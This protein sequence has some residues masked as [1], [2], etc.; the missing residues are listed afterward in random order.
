MPWCYITY[1]LLWC[2]IH[3]DIQWR[4]VIHRDILWYV[5]HLQMIYW[6]PPP[7]GKILY[8]IFFWK[9]NSYYFSLWKFTS[10]TKRRIIVVKDMLVI[11]QATLDYVWSWAS[12][13]P[14]W[15]WITWRASEML[16]R[17]LTFILSG[18]DRFIILFRAKQGRAALYDA[19]KYVMFPSAAALVFLLYILLLHDVLSHF[20][21]KSPHT[22]KASTVRVYR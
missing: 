15:D 2:I 11:L 5:I 6:I 19:S 16:N 17:I 9:V 1:K 13:C 8:R 18:S 22:S 20:W 4:T 12:A 7:V 3:N 14:I 21:P 10:D